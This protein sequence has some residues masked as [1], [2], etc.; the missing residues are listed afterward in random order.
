[1]TDY[2]AFSKDHKCP[3]W[4]DYEI[5]RQEL[6]EADELCHGNWIEIQHQYEYILRLQEL[7]TQHGIEIPPEY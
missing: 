3:K 6:E 7:L 1:M 2:C 5:T 4:T